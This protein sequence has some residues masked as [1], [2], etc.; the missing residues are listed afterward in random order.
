[1]CIMDHCSKEE[2]RIVYKTIGDIVTFLYMCIMDI[3]EIHTTLLSPI[4]CFSLYSS[5]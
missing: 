3:D 1:M 2:T 5:K 4:F